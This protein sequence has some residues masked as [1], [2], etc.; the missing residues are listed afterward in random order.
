M[1]SVSPSYH[2]PPEHCYLTDL[3]SQ[4]VLSPTIWI[5]LQLLEILSEPRFQP[6]I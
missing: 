5:H 6:L 1:F 2:S 3:K 4:W